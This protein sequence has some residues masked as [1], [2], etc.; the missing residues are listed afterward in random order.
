[1][2]ARCVVVLKSAMKCAHVI[3]SIADEA[4]GTSYVTARMATAQQELG[5]DVS[6]L[7][8]S[9]ESSSQS[10]TF[11]HLE[12]KQ[13][14]TFWRPLSKLGYSRAMKQMLYQLEVDVFH[15]HGLW[16][17]LNIYPAAAARSRRLPLI[18][19][20]HGMMGRDALRFSAHVKS[21]FWQVWQKKVLTEVA[22]FHATAPSEYE[23]IRALG[24][25]QPVAIVPNGI[26]LPCLDSVPV[27]RVE[28]AQERQERPFVLSLGRIHRKKA[29]DRL[30]A[31]WAQVVADYPSWQLRLVGPDEGGYSD[32]L[33]RQ[34]DAL[35]LTHCISIEA[36]VFGAQK[37]A[38]MREAAL[39]ALPTLH[40]NFAITVAESLALE[41][42]VI[43]TKGAPWQGLV[44]HHCGWWI[45]HGADAMA[46]ALRDAMA[47]SPDQRQAMGERGRLWMEQ[48]FS[49]DKIARQ[50]EQVYS[51]LAKGAKCPDCVVKD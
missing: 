12:C 23:D 46:S 19:A 18:T 44:D 50:M 15:T 29:L 40:E 42:P 31:A 45:D 21:V 30:V 38:L 9:S 13:D 6:V 36:P 3:S 26:D 27:T 22:C 11:T 2:V 7:S 35:G 28:K 41:T 39:F 1:M 5:L 25:R 10:K 51:W 17:M 8:L 34:I 24:F 16:M 4:A 49:W 14:L 32:E 33:R 37:H 47:L 48:D 20:P 43:S